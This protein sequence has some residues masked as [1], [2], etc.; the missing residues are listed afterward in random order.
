MLPQHHRGVADYL[1]S[2][3]IVL[4]AC[5]LMAPAG[6]LSP[7]ATTRLEPISAP[8]GSKKHE[9]NLSKARSAGAISMS[10]FVPLV[11]FNRVVES[12]AHRTAPVSPMSTPSRQTSTFQTPSQLKAEAGTMMGAEGTSVGTETWGQ[13]RPAKF[14]MTV[15]EY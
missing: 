6:S 7:V 4:R 15:C 3:S 9:L 12:G 1:R 11:E 13:E 2:A 5:W 14:S 8:T 10:L